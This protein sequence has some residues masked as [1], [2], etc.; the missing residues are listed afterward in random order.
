MKAA[1]NS[2][3]PEAI[4]IRMSTGQLRSLDA[5]AAYEKV[6]RSAVVRRL[7]PPLHLDHIDEPAAS[8]D[9]GAA[10]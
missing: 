8:A 2:A 1:V 9:V 6:S 7:I 10:G 4:L 3:L 5:I